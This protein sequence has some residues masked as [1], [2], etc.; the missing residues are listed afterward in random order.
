MPR[1]SHTLAHKADHLKY[2]AHTSHI[3]ASR[4]QPQAQEEIRYMQTPTTVLAWFQGQ[5]SILAILLAVA[6]VFL[7]VLAASSYARRR[8]LAHTRSGDDMASYLQTM[9]S[10]GFDPEIARLAYAFL[11]D[12]LAI[13][14]PV[15]PED[16]LDR[17]L[18]ISE[19]E[20]GDMLAFMLFTSG[21][22][23]SPHS[24]PNTLTTVADMVQRVQTSPLQRHAAA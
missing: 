3:C 23:D 5:G 2:I 18:G 14:Y 9:Q 19:S 21:R 12:R 17:D 6:A 20:I 15:L 24:T 22:V 13:D 7:L 11:Q 4:Y 1:Q 8:H 10:R 16:E